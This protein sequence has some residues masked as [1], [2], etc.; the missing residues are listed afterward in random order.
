MLLPVVTYPA[1]SLKKESKEVKEFGQEWLRSLIENMFETMYHENGIGLAAPQIGENINLFVMDVAKPDPNDPEQYIS[2]QIYMI[3]PKIVH[4]EGSILYEEGCLSCPELLVK[5]ERSR[6][7]LVES[8]DVNGEL[9]KHR[10]SELQAV[11]TQHEMDHLKGILLTDHVSQ[12]K[13]EMYGKKLMRQ[14]ENED[15]IS[16]LE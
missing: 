7:I 11:C 3:N 16:I 4:A 6:D 8:K 2:D 13:R 5:V 14:R 12:L 9:Q 1:L 15:D 10:L